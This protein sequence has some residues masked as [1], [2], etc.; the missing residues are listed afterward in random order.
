MTN[1]N[2]MQDHKNFDNPVI[3]Y[4]GLGETGVKLVETLAMIGLKGVE[5]YSLDTDN[6][7]LSRC[8]Q[9]KTLLLGKSIPCGLGAGGDIALARAAV[10]S[11]R[12]HILKLISGADLV[13]VIAGM[14]GGTGTEAAPFVGRLA[15]ESGALVVGIAA[16]PFNCEGTRRCNKAA[17][18]IRDLK[19]VS[20]VVFHFSNEEVM[21]IAGGEISLN[22][23]L[24]LANRHLCESVLGLSRMLIEPGHLNVSFGDLQAS[25]KGLHSLGSTLCVEGAGEDLAADAIQK[26]LSHPAARK[27]KALSEATTLLMHLTGGENLSLNEINTVVESICSHASSNDLIVGASGN[28]SDNVLKV[29]LV[30]VH[31]VKDSI[32]DANTSK[33]LKSNEPLDLSYPENFMPSGENSYI[34]L[35]AESKGSNRVRF[36]YTPPAPSVETITPE[37]KDSLLEAAASQEPSRKK[38]KEIKQEM[39]PLEVVSKGRFE[40]SEPTI[41]KGE[42][43]DQPTYIRRGMLLN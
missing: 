20:D 28:G 2:L 10:E 24:E 11:D 38:R 15:K 32:T 30:I 9:S 23:A 13:F 3:R 16:T 35:G 27:G 21:Q 29:I 37:M 6:R 39:L 26:I 41:H 14:G 40:K 43:L 25:M 5:S 19:Q 34:G 22:K 36:A 1:S 42:D 33:N 18:G 12:D 4:I 7:S 8:H 17:G 31:E